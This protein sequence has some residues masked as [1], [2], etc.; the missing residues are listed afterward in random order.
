MYLQYGNYRHASYEGAV[1]VE[2]L[3]IIV[4]GMPVGH[5]ERWHVQGMLTAADMAT[6]VAGMAAL[7]AS[8]SVN[9][10]S[11]GLYSAD[12]ATVRLLNSSQCAGGTRVTMR[13]AAPIA[14]GAELTTYAHY[15]LIVEGDIYDSNV[16][17]LS[18]FESLS[19]QGTCGPD[20]VFLPTLNGLP[21]VQMARQ[22]TTCKAVQTGGAVGR[23]SYPSFP[24]PMWGSPN[25]Q[26]SLRQIR[27]DPPRRV[28]R[29]GNHQYTEYPISWTY[30]FESN[31]PLMGYPHL[32]PL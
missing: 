32:W 3:P 25:E 8:Y 11:I 22:R 31:E 16:T 18:F 13:P 9:G 12:G 23:L 26:E 28:G 14:G 17:L 15:N 27:F 24:P 20:I 21:Q 4:A 19:F 2:K 30:Y 7:E 1:M 5:T 10:R 29:Y 6:V